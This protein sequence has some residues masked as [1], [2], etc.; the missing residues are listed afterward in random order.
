V[1]LE[2]DQNFPSFDE[3]RVELRRIHD[4]YQRATGAAWD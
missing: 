4:I 1:L 3:L 2:R